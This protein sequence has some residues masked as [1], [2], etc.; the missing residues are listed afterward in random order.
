VALQGIG[1]SDD[2][3]SELQLILRANPNSVE[4]KFRLG[5]VELNLKNYQAAER[6]LQQCLD[7]SGRNVLCVVGLAEVYSSQHQFDKAIQVLAAEQAR[8]PG[9]PGV[10]LALANTSVL[11]GRY[12][13]AAKLFS[14]M[15][16]GDPASTD[17]HL[18]LA[19]TYRR[20]GNTSGALEHF[21]KVK[22]LQP[23]NPDAA[24]WL[25][26]LLHQTG[27]EAEAKTQYEQIL[28][29]QPDNPIALNNLAYVLAEQGG[30]L[31]VALTY[32]QRAKQRL[33][34]SPDVA[35]TLGWIYIK[36]NLTSSALEIY[37]D[38][39]AKWPG[40]AVYR[41]HLGMALLQKGDR[42]RAQKELE[43][44]LRS[45]PSP[46]DA[47]KIKELLQKIG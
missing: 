9:R 10:R 12:D 35:D 33:P 19:E 18:R 47:G 22:E 26:L 27:R 34:A 5:M 31:D 25:A 6:A 39:V 7:T 14:D 42:L 38:L 36:K 8:N 13:A 16:A 46:Q 2:A 30:D 41:Y 4:A 45:N 37:S 17:L 23:T 3:R 32:A 29:L 40:T 28:R 24:I 20:M 15:L 44:A 1:R 21:R 11:A 43:A